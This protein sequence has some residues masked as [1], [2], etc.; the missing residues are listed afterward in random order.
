MFDNSS[1]HFHIAELL[2]VQTGT[3]NDQVLRPYTA[4]ADPRRVMQLHETTFGGRQFNVNALAGIAGQILVPATNHQGIIPIANGWNESRFRFLMRVECGGPFGDDTIYIITGYTDHA[5][6][7]FSR[8]LDPNMSFFINNI[9]A[10]TVAIEQTSMG[11]IERLR[12]ANASHV[13][14]DQFNNNLHSMRPEDVFSTLSASMYTS[15]EDYRTNFRM[16][17]KLSKRNNGSAPSYLGKALD[18]HRQAMSQSESY[19]DLT[20][21]MSNASGFVKDSTPSDISPL[22]I[23]SQK[24]GWRQNNAVTF[25]ELERLSPNLHD[26]THVQLAAQLPQPAPHSGQSEHFS[27]LNGETIAVT[28]LSQSI[29]SLM[30][31]CILTHVWFNVTND[32]LGGNYEFNFGDAGGFSDMDISPFLQSFQDRFLAEIFNDITRSNNIVISL[33]VRI[34]IRG[35]SF[36]EINFDNQGFVEYIIP[37]F[38]DALMTP[39]MTTTTED[40]A[41]LS[42]TIS[43]LADQ[44]SYS[45]E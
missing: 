3:Y 42:N 5:D 8:L 31:D 12:L 39:V 33:Q 26:V 27:G 4:N 6:T 21:I 17:S 43:H 35:D 40:L 22:F 13:L 25:T 7:S 2:M 20:A 45:Y 34:D 14:S 29:P 41:G 18:A 19:D 10:L 11:P 44:L 23:L 36:F 28:M 9:I 24:T 16:G 38:S 37:T 15:K 1:Y 30:M 32:T